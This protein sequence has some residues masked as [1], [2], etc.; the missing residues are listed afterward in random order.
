M[1]LTDP[2]LT[3]LFERAQQAQRKA[4]HKRQRR[5][6]R[7]SDPA[8]RPIINPE[9][10]LRS[11][12][13]KIG[14]HYEHAA[15]LMLEQHGFELLA[16]QLTCPLGELDLVVRKDR[17]LVFVEVRRRTS[18]NFGGAASS[19]C[20]RKQRRLQLT[21]QWWLPTLVRQYFRHEQ[22]ACRFDI[23]AYEPGGVTW[24]QDAVR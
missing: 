13:Q 3:A 5:L 15:W 16:R 4:L 20:K 7:P 17:L 24:H 19:V 1:P 2:L 14:D 8:P 10:L 22:P 11:A 18:P 12:R 6:A 21:A 23:I 9:A